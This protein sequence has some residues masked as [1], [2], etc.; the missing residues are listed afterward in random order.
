MHSD[1]L[2]FSTTFV[3][4]RKLSGSSYS[5]FGFLA[6]IKHNRVYQKLLNCTRVQFSNFEKLGLNTFENPIFYTLLTR[7]GFLEV[8]ITTLPL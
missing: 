8:Q 3:R 7:T 6:Y 4:M 1:V 2:V 5:L